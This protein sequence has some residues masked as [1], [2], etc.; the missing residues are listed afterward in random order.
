MKL[1]EFQFRE[2]ECLRD[3]DE[4]ETSGFVVPRAI[5]GRMQNL[6]DGDRAEWAGL[7]NADN[8]EV[9]AGGRAE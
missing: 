9:E 3:F 4:E 8:E 7:L 2:M 1:S 5:G 6:K